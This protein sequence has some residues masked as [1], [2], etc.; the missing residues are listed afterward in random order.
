MGIIRKIIYPLDCGAV[1]LCLEVQPVGVGVRVEGEGVRDGG[2][3]PIT[4]SGFLAILLTFL[5]KSV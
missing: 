4:H 5:R 2:H 1:P 3:D